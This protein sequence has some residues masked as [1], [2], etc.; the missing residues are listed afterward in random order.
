MKPIIKEGDINLGVHIRRG[1]YIKWE[2]GNY[3][4]DDEFYIDLIKQFLLLFTNKKVNIFIS[5]NFNGFVLQKFA[6]ILDKT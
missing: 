3:F 4:F 2:N 6:F 1:D 5:T